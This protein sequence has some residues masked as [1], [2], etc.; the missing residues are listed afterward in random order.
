MTIKW[1]EQCQEFLQMRYFFDSGLGTFNTLDGNLP[2][3]MP[4]AAVLA[5]APAEGQP[6]T[7]AA[8]PHTGCRPP[9]ALNIN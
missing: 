5:A 4:P 3:K 1:L 9:P 2:P 8:V 6:P 7:P